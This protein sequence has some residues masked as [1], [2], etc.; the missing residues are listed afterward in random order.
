MF[1]C[2]FVFLSPGLEGDENLKFLLIGGDLTKIKSSSWKKKRYFKLLEDGHTMWSESRKGFRRNQTC[3]SSLSTRG[4]F[5]LHLRVR[6]R[7]LAGTFI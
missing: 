4:S 3:E 7:H 6:L 1:V 2:L 5:T